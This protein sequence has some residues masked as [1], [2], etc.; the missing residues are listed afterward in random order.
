M[1]KSFRPASSQPR[2]V[3]TSFTNGIPQIR[4]PQEPNSRHD[5]QPADK[6]AHEAPPVKSGLPAI[7]SNLAN[8]D[9]DDLIL[10]AL[11]A[12][13]VSQNGEVDIVLVCVLLYV[14]LF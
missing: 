13:I 14:F 9:T 4:T 7:A 1:D 3:P 2:I 12:F 10:I 8:I 5:F 11:I 6:N